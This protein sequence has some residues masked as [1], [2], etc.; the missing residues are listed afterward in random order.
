MLHSLHP[1]QDENCQPY[2]PSKRLGG[3]TVRKFGPAGS[4]PLSKQVGLS[5]ARKALGN[6]TNK[7]VQQQEGA[8]PFKNTPGLHGQRKALGDI[9]N[10]TPAGQAK[11]VKALLEKPAQQ[12]GSAAKSRLAKQKS[13]AEEYAEDGIERLAGKSQAQLEADRGLR[14]MQD[15]I[16]RAAHIASLPTLWPPLMPWAKVQQ[17]LHWLHQILS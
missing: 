5:S 3:E 16:N 6:I 11:N 9:T 17:L 8:T 10:A 14:D 7:K 12:K 4:T 2:A 1:L 13:R 15:A